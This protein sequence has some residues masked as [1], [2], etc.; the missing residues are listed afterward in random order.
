MIDQ[1]EGADDLQL[2]SWSI[3]SAVS[4]GLEIQFG[5]PTQ[6]IDNTSAAVFGMG[7]CFGRC[8]KRMRYS[9]LSKATKV[10]DHTLFSF[11]LCYFLNFNRNFSLCI[12]PIK[13]N[14]MR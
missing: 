7:I 9:C 12:R 5:N 2:K 6:E 14:Y 4:I 1:S 11:I 3:L 13:K 10:K 8:Y